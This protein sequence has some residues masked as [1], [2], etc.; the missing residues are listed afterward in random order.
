MPS[1]ADLVLWLMTT[2][3]ELFV[4]GLIIVQGMFRKFP[5]LNLYLLA[6]IAA[7]ISRYAVYNNFGLASSNYVYTYYYTD[8]LLSL[9]LF[10]SVCELTVRLV[11]AVIRTW[12]IILFCA[13]VFVFIVALSVSMAPFWD[14]HSVIELSANLFDASLL[15][16]A[17][18][19]CF[20]SLRNRPANRIAARLVIVVAIYLSVIFLNYEA[21]QYLPRAYDPSI[22]SEM[23][24][25]WLPLGC[26]FALISNQRPPATEV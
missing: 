22:L 7:N 13:G 12:K 14:T 23:A 10:L 26:G 2:L 17:A 11:G 21:C 20:W 9:T 18:L 1:T 8:A 3:V 4:L 19:I 6:C 25:A 24:G 15:G 5:F 16:I